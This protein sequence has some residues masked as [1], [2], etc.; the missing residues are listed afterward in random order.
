M[1]HIA[2][3][4]AKIKADYPWTPVLSDALKEALIVEIQKH[5]QGYG[6]KAVTVEIEQDAPST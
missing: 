3:F 4:T 2:R 1:M 5:L 6:F